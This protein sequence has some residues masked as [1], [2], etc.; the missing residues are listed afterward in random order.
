MDTAGPSSVLPVLYLDL[1]GVV[2]FTGSRTQYAKRSGFGHM[3]RGSLLDPSKNS[4][5]A[6]TRRNN[7]LDLNWSAE[8]LR[9]L[10]ALPVELVV[11]STWRHHFADFKRATQWNDLESYRV[12]DWT[13]GPRGSEHAGKVPALVAD[14]LAHPRP[15]IWA[16]DEAHAFYSDADRAALSAVP[17]LLLTTDEKLGLTLAD[18]TAMLDFLAELEGNS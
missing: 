6:F 10:A 3:R 2:N 13:D 8:L 14:Q 4:Y 1:D 7:L 17:S 9:K 12:L 18:Y 5:D 11:L 16:D 15:F